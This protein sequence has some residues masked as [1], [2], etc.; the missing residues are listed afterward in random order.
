MQRKPII[1]SIIRESRADDK[2]TP[3]VP[4]QVKELLS[5][6]PNLKILVQPSK[7]R[8]FKDENYFSVEPI[9]DNAENESE[10]NQRRTL[11]E[12]HDSYEKGA[13]GS[14]K[15]KYGDGQSFELPRRFEKPAGQ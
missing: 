4:R 10:R 11:Y 7:N 14:F 9:R 1:I 3:L 15:Y 6:H 2:R 13:P 8:C 12:Q 5:K